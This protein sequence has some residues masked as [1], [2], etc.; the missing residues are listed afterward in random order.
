MAAT[1]TTKTPTN[2][3]A[4]KNDI[5]FPLFLNVIRVAPLQHTPE[6]FAIGEP[7]D[8]LNRHV[9]RKLFCGLG[10]RINES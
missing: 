8:R 6:L 5:C 1:L 7:M 4:L 10:L 2:K 3:S 9:F